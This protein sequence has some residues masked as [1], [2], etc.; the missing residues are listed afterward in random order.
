MIDLE[1]T[2]TSKLIGK[3]S[4]NYLQKVTNIKLLFL[5][6]VLISQAC[7]GQDTIVTTERFLIGSTVLVG[8]NR[9]MESCIMHGKM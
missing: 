6:L 5:G 9:N 1:N 7:L 3:L 2:I 8:S 4:K